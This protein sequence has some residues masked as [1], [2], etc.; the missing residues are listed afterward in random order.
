MVLFHPSFSN[1]KHQIY[2]HD[3]YIPMKILAANNSAF[4][5]KCLVAALCISSSASAWAWGTDYAA[6]DCTQKFSMVK[7]TM[8]FIGIE[9]VKDLPPDAEK[10][11]PS[12]LIAPD[13]TSSKSLEIG[14]A[15]AMSLIN[16]GLGVGMLLSSF[17]NTTN[18]AEHLIV[19][20]IM[21]TSA[22]EGRPPNQVAGDAMANGLKQLL[23]FT[24]QERYNR[25]IFTVKGGEICGED[26]CRIHSGLF[27]DYKH[28]EKLG[29]KHLNQAPSWLEI[30]GPIYVYRAAI[31]R[32]QKLG[33]NGSGDA[34]ISQK[35]AIALST[36]LPDYFYI[37]LP[38]DDSKT[39]SV[40]L[41]AGKTHYAI[42][43]GIPGN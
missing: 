37:Y 41:N 17:V 6:D 43:P 16:R 20:V 26:G 25:T 14:A 13:R 42:S 30:D 3:D 19:F 28:E 32:L 39:P 12:L 35:A 18:Y 21:P 7:C 27:S 22:A 10:K 24:D 40:L 2:T 38:S 5:A 9:K 4:V 8:G 1:H 33:P 29:G 15:G 36:F 23:Q 34:V 31:P 11:G